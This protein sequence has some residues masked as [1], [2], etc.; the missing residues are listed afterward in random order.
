MPVTMTLIFF[1][2]NFWVFS[3]LVAS[4]F[5]LS[6]PVFFGNYAFSQAT[7]TQSAA[8]GINVKAQVGFNTLTVTGFITPQ[9]LL[10]LRTLEG[11]FIIDTTANAQGYFTFPVTYI[12]E[13]FNGFC[14]YA[15][16]I[17]TVGSSEVCFNR[18]APTGNIEMLDLFLPPTVSTPPSE[19]QRGEVVTIKGY[20]MP[21]A[22]VQLRINTDKVLYVNAD[23]NGYYSFDIENA[24]IGN[25]IMYAIAVLDG[26][27]SLKPAKSLEVIVL[28]AA[29]AKSNLWIFILIFLLL[30]LIALII[31]LL[32]KKKVR[33][34]IEQ[35]VKRVTRS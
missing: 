9:A 16:D 19:I 12:N 24:S 33:A 31:Y 26:R 20:T 21:H 22:Q 30:L 18:E 14:I 23:S 32:R 6:S 5:L 25:Y 3:G 2:A 27:E 15:K 17:L 7:E 8:S 13:N 11:R 10:S 29:F 1:R 4:F 35:I 28:G 34:R